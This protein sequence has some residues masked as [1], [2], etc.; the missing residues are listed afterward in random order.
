[1]QGSTLSCKNMNNQSEQASPL[2]SR[3]TNYK[4]GLT[5]EN[6]QCATQSFL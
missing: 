6:T 5:V 3:N 1:M 2:K 4:A